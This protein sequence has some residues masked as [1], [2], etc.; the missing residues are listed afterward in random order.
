MLTLVTLSLSVEEASFS[1]SLIWIYITDDAGV[2]FFDVSAINY[3]G[4][5]RG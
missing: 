2:T 1:D 4:L 3:L 5:Y